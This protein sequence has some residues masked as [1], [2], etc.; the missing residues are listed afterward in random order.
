MSES[1][2]DFFP[3]HE[4][5]RSRVLNQ[6]SGDKLPH[7]LLLCGPEHVGKNRFARALASFL[8]CREPGDSNCGQCSTCN[9][10]AA[11][12][13][14][15]FRLVQPVESKLIRIEQIR[16]L[17]DWATQTAQMSGRKVAVLSPAEQ[18]NH[19][20]ANALLKC[21]EEP[22]PGTVLILVS[23]QPGRLLPTIRSRCQR[24]DFPVPPAKDVLPWLEGIVGKDAD[25]EMLLSMVGGAPLA[26]AETMDEEYLARRQKIIT[27]VAEL[28]ES[29]RAPLAVAEE[30]AKLDADETLEILEGML[31]DTLKI[32]LMKG[33]RFLRNRDMTDLA[34][35]MAGRLDR[36][37]LLGLIDRLSAERRALQ[38]PSNLNVQ[39]LLEGVLVEFCGGQVD[40]IYN[41]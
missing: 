2:T 9:L 30:L 34:Q 39:L 21:L 1:D 33:D 27:A 26:V 25:A 3:W 20:S 13:H 14:P 16:D 5:Q 32:T 10:F 8:L 24:I 41:L 23:S 18:M 15:D 11:G 40:D 36:A 31:I 29:G 37:R 22:A 35:K 19:Q 6:H 28:A 38:G 17:I 4:R 7:A 12:T